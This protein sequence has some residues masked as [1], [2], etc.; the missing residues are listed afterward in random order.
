MFL[1]DPKEG[2]ITMARGLFPALGSFPLGQQISVIDLCHNYG[3]DQLAKLGGPVVDAIRRGDWM[4][5]GDAVL[6]LPFAGTTFG[7]ASAA[8]A[9]AIRT[10]LQTPREPDPC[11]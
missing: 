11:S 10:G 8:C 5:A 6:H 4:A 3:V 9:N 2:L 7:R 1:T